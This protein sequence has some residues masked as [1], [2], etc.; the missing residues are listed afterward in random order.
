MQSSI[1][2]VNLLAMPA[3]AGIM[4]LASPIL[5]ALYNDPRQ[6]PSDMLVILGAA[7]LFVCL[8]FVTTAI[9]Q[10]NGFERVALI[11]FPVGR[12]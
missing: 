2:L 1:K 3:S 11:T 8:Q 12:L 5:T 10:A 6:L 4:V 9:L 7:T